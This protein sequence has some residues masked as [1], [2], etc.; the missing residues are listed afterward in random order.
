MTPHRAPFVS[1][2]R[3]RRNAALIVCVVAIALTA[4]P[5]ANSQVTP[6]YVF[7]EISVPGY[8]NIR[9]QG[10][11]NLGQ[12]VGTLASDTG[13]HGF[14]LQP[15]GDWRV[16]T[17]PV[18]GTVTLI[19]YPNAQGSF[20]GINDSGAIVGSVDD[21]TGGR[22]G[23]LY[24]GGVF[25]D[26]IYPGA[27]ITEVTGINNVGTIVGYYSNPG[28]TVTHGFRFDGTNYVQ[29]D[30]PGATSTRL[31]GISNDDRLCGSTPAGSFVSN[32]GNI[33]AV[34]VSSFF[35][36]KSD[37]GLVTSINSNGWFIG[38]AL[39]SLLQFRGFL[40]YGSYIEL[41][42]LGG[43]QDPRSLNDHNEVVGVSSPTFN[44]V[45][46]YA[47][48]QNTIVAQQVLNGVE[49]NGALYQILVP[50]AWN[51][52]LV[53]YAHGIVNPGEPLQLPNTDPR[54]ASLAQAI[55]D[56]GYA[57]AYSSYAVNGYAVQSG[58]DSTHELKTIFNSLVGPP[59]HTFITG[60]SEG[61][62]VTLALAEKYP[63]DFNGA[64]A[65]CGP[66]GGSIPEVQYLGD[67]RA[68][69]DMFFASFP[70][71]LPGSIANPIT[72]DFSPNSAAFNGVA[73]NLIQGL[74]PLYATQQLVSTAKI[75]A[76]NANEAVA[77]ALLSVGYSVQF[78]QDL[79]Q[80]AGG[81]VYNNT[82]TIYHD[83]VIPQFD[84]FVNLGVARVA[85][86][87]AAVAFLKSEY[88]PTGNLQIPMFTLHTTRDP[89]VPAFH[90]DL[91]AHIVA[92]ASA[93]NLF[94]QRIDR[95]GHCSFTDAETLAAFDALVQWVNTGTRP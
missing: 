91:Y 92:A 60:H 28:E 5:F 66:I 34:N 59:H 46:Y 22:K 88:T 37:S 49:S 61:G 38:K 79:I 74:L 3:S 33:T 27:S 54:F 19:D 13:T 67:A 87:P 51:G 40:N 44:T 72:V 12:V 10:I 39:Y 85:A 83:A 73:T 57:I 16:G 47:Y 31:A 84:L 56:R 43:D 2:F 29:Y 25:H 11:N 21:G 23:F 32:N 80:K 68:L 95:W 50:A 4:P 9:P 6:Q 62:L 52:D 14:L 63:Q 35:G 45:P 7:R 69:Y 90:E 36:G 64:L 93:Q 81:Q 71:K 42:G 82:T 26:V 15:Q 1:L 77:G 18:T 48:D 55:L 20:V 89:L 8:G 41:T 53:L 70:Y 94:Q 17:G 65:M 30:V 76:S 75:P 78:G 58:I 24:E 86:N